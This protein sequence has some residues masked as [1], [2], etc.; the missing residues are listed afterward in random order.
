MKSRKEIIAWLV[1]QIAEVNGVAPVTI[2]TTAPFTSLGLDSATSI[3]LAGDLEAW[4]G[5]DVDGTALFEH[6][7]I[8]RL[9]AH[10]SALAKP[11]GLS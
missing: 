9:A 7:T 6:P 2:S 11:A 8:E 5:I 3:T 4:L 10:L 1:A